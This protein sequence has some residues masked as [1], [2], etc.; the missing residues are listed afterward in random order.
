MPPKMKTPPSYRPDWP[1]QL[2]LRKPSGFVLI[3]VLL[4]LS[5]TVVFVVVTSILTQ[6]ERRAAAN[7][8]RTETA[9]QNALFAL[10]AALSQLQKEAG[11]DQRITARAEILDSSPTTKS[12]DD[13]KQPYW[14]GVWKTGDK[15]LD[16]AVS[17]KAQRE[18]SL[19]NLKPDFSDKSTNAVWLVSTPSEGGGLVKV[20]PLKELDT[21]KYSVATVAYVKNGGSTLSI[22]VPLV[23]VK[24]TLA[25]NT[26][27][28]AVG[29][30]GYWVSDEGVKAKV[31]MKDYT[32]GQSSNIINQNHFLTSQAYA[33]HAAI[34]DFKKDLREDPNSRYQKVT[35]VDS[36][37]YFS[38]ITPTAAFSQTY[39]PDLTTYSYG[40]IS[41]AK[42]GGLK[43]DLT[44]ALE[45]NNSGS[46]MF[47]RLRNRCR[48]LIGNND[49]QDLEHVYRSNNPKLAY[50]TQIA[51]AAS[52]STMLDGLR[53]QS[54]YFYYNLYKNTIPMWRAATTGTAPAGVLT[55]DLSGK[56]KIQQTVFRYRDVGGATITMDSI[57]PVPM[58]MRMDVAIESFLSA[59]T[60]RLRLRYYPFMALYNPYGAAIYNSQ[61]TIYSYNSN[62]GVVNNRWQLDLK[63]NGTNVPPFSG[64]AGS[65]PFQGSLPAPG[66]GPP[67][68]AAAGNQTSSMEPGEIRAYGLTSDVSKATLGDPSTTNVGV[69]NDLL[70]SQIFSLDYAQTYTL[71]WAGTTNATHSVTLSVGNKQISA[72]STRF[73]ARSINAW[74]DGGG[75]NITAEIPVAQPPDTTPTN[76]WTPIAISLMNG[77]PYFI[78]GFNIR[79]KGLKASGGA[80]AYK[81]SEYNPPI[82]MGNSLCYDPYA[83]RGGGNTT[84]FWWEMLGRAFTQ[85]ATIP[86]VNYSLQAA[87]QSTQT[88][89]GEESAGSAIVNNNN[90][91]LP[92]ID[93][94]K[95]PLVSLGQFMHLS[96]RYF[97]GVG[98]Y[99]SL[100]ISRMAV[101]G[102]LASPNVPTDYNTN[103][104]DAANGTSTSIMFDDSFMANQVLFDSYF[105]STVPAKSQ[106][107]TDKDK[108][109][110]WGGDLEKVVTN[111]GN[112]Q[113]GRMR[114]Y[115]DGGTIPSNTS[116]YVNDLRDLEAAAGKLWIDGAFNVNSTSVIAWQ[117]L[118]CSLSGKNNNYNVWGTANK[119]I[120]A[121][122]QFV[123]PIPRF[124]N[125]TRGSTTGKISATNTLFQS[126]RSF[127]DEQMK[128]LAEK[129]VEQVKKRGPFLTMG[130]FLNRRLGQKGELTNMGALQAAIDSALL[131]GVAGIPS[132]PTKIHPNN[133]PFGLNVYSQIGSNSFPY[134]LDG[135]NTYIPPMAATGATGYLMQQ[136]LV[137]AFAPTMAVRSDT[138]IIRCYGEV[139]NPKTGAVES[140]AYGE[141]VVQRTPILFDSTQKPETYP[142]SFNDNNKRFGRKFKLVAFRWINEK[143]I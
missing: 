3:T 110:V 11:P 9:R 57:A 29:R 124:F 141:A 125:V 126:F 30:Y 86:E 12:I 43:V 36:V 56:L 127:T 112:L 13:V 16:V 64:A 103:L 73:V 72:N 63:V 28:T 10:D 74:P 67:A 142:T 60:Y 114:F 66:G 24:T 26:E 98:K 87:G 58:L 139:L 1:E 111:N 79:A 37:Q 23:E 39:S 97:S 59:G 65:N 116:A 89:W 7:S 2:G 120:V 121:I 69:A 21:S 82:F 4:I 135:S 35:T 138:F 42:N 99:Q 54:L 137:Q 123:N 46:G 113:N 75:A 131:N 25:N 61:N 14:T 90:S 71:P 53:W 48:T 115:F 107:L 101:G 117:S 122:S 68:W 84:T 20:D 50:P 106:S 31:N 91:F 70:S 78:Y 62:L 27:S 85:Y 81:S 140:K 55:S 51:V 18:I 8:A 104:T 105:L 128:T 118:L 40:V 143:N 22:K 136:D 109:V 52:G 130:D 38:N 80:T 76:N 19:G 17:G 94:P 45:D 92:L 134:K 33:P 32:W 77:N 102:S 6:V 129:I 15:M 88:S 108:Y 132:T 96:P 83:P 95:Q 47:V 41:D 44:A 5:V 100:A 119:D 133:D 34:S 49:S 93:V